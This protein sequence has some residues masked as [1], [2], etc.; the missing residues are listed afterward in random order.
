MKRTLPCNCGSK[1]KCLFCPLPP[2]EC[3]LS[4]LSGYSLPGRSIVSL[5]NVLLIKS[6]NPQKKEKTQ[7][8]VQSTKFYPEGRAL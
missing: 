2:Q 6:G 1:D 8:T 4:A 7:L 3:D 5:N